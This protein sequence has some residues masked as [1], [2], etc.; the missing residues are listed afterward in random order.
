LVQYAPGDH[1]IVAQDRFA[2]V[3]RVLG[4]EH[5]GAGA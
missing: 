3:Y 4:G 1:G 2:S 5:L